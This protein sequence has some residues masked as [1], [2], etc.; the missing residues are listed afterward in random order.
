[1]RRVAVTG[2]GVVSCIG[3]DLASVAESLKA[4][5]SGITAAPEYAQLGFR[6]QV[7][8]RPEADTAAIDKRL[9]RFM[10]DGAAWAYL[11]A[12]EAIENAGLSATE[13][14][15]PKTA[16]IAGSGGPSTAA[17]V[18]AADT[19]REKGPR[20]V[21]PFAVPKCMC[22]TLSA[23]LATALKIQ[24]PSYSISS[25][26]ATSGHCIANAADLV[27]L[28]RADVA[29]AGGGEELDWALSVLF[30][31]MGALSC[32]YNDRPAAAS[33]PYDANRDGF[34]I[35]G[36]AG[37]L[38]L[39]DMD[40]ARARGARVYAELLGHGATS[41]GADMVAPSGEGAVRCMRQALSGID[42]ARVTYINTH[43]T[44]TPAGD[45]TELTAIKE[46]FGERVPPLS[47]TKS[48][49]GHSLGAT[50]AQEA[51]FSILMMTE[52]FIS[53][54]VGIETLDD[55][56]A[57]API[58]TERRDGVAHDVVLSNSFGFGGTNCT[59]AFGRGEG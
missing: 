14:A 39:E 16:L 8:G 30:D 10:G 41:D 31:A 44:S 28:G 7:W 13:V 56:A 22:S 53:P 25:A 21:G 5:R 37:M 38:V 19:A 46:V 36:G 47:S 11:A 35:A 45:I 34:V 3:N 43:G 26:C 24:G 1:M 55:G 42:P 59:L 17:Q 23:N 20:R 32:G 9:L 54:S 57:G 2:M 40:R 52:G 6:S 51:V 48:L 15:S 27:R 58:V 18:A 50:S 29:L 49:T 4:G 33:R 12:L